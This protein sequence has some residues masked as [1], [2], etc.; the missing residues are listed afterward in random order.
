MLLV[1]YIRLGSQSKFSLIEFSVFTIGFSA[2]RYV[3]ILFFLSEHLPEYTLFHYPNRALPAT[4]FGSASLLFLGYSYAI[5]EWGLAARQRYAERSKKLKKKFDQPI[6][7]RCGGKTVYILPQDI[8]Y[9]QANG[10]YVDYKT[11]TKKYTCFKRLKDVQTELS[12]Y[13]FVRTHRSFIINP[14]YVESLTATE[15]GLKEGT[16]VPLSKTYKEKVTTLIESGAS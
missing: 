15:I 10:E 2:V 7:L 1:G 6:L 5:Y 12:E 14:S 13:G 16:T 3:Y 4:V 11:T 8:V 9:I